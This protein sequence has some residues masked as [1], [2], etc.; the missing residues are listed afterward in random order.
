M[1]NPQA[2]LAMARRQNA[3]QMGGNGLPDQANQMAQQNAF[4]MN[5]MAQGQ[6]LP[7]P[8]PESPSQNSFMRMNPMAQARSQ[9]AMGSGRGAVPR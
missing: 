3:Q 9:F 6:Q 4:G 8:P 2:M 5:P 1:M 7:L